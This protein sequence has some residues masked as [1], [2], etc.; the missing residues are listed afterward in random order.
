MVFGELFEWEGEGMIAA[1]IVLSWCFVVAAACVLGFS[2]EL[3]TSIERE[4]QLSSSLRFAHKRCEMLLLELHESDR[5]Q[6]KEF[7]RILRELP[8]DVPGLPFI[9][10]LLQGEK[11]HTASH[12]FM[13]KNIIPD[14]MVVTALRF[15]AL[16]VYGIFGVTCG[17]ERNGWV[18]IRGDVLDQARKPVYVACEWCGHGTRV[19]G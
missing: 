12:C 16:R 17:W 3:E 4:K 2:R 15:N 6:Y 11:S 7:D 18:M 19:R 13:S 5:D 8:L 1:V 9:Y 10:D 14:D